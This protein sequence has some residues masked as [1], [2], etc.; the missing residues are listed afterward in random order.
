MRPAAV[1]IALGACGAPAV[2]PVRHPVPP[3]PDVPASRPA[4]P[5]SRLA[6]P[7]PAPIDPVA[8]LTPGAATRIAWLEAGGL[9]LE[10]GGG[11][12][13]AP[14]AAPLQVSIVERLGSHVRIAIRLPHVWFAAWA[15]RAQL[16]AIVR[17]RTLVGPWAGTQ[18]VGRT[19]AT[20]KPGA[21]VRR[22]GHARG[23]TQ[24]RYEGQV[25]VEGWVP[26]AALGEEVPV[27]V[28]GRVPA[29]RGRLL[30]MSGTVLRAEASR[31]GRALAVIAGARMIEPRGELPDGWIEGAYGDAEVE[32]VGY[33]APRAP[34]QRPRAPRHEP[35]AAPVAVV[36]TAKVAAGTCLHARA[37]GEPIGYV[38]GDREG[39]LVAIGDALLGERWWTLTLDSPW[40]GLPFAV[41]GPTPA[42]LATCQPPAPTA[43]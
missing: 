3:A 23:F 5:A 38:F 1:L 2:T 40:G 20:L 16:L 24:V 12:F 26:D 18:L 29:L 42:D 36:P 15:D 7:P 10:L 14:A 13:D 33:Y 21:R 32:V 22:L 8:S 9:Q 37:T 27:G 4:D 28:L 6:A 30:V 41:R 17:E 34:M 43:P 39:D 19:H 31:T 25:E 35:D 11:W